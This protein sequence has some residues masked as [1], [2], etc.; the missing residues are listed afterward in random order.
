MKMT[1]LP[2]FEGE[3][4]VLWI[5]AGIHYHV[6][7]APLLLLRLTLPYRKHLCIYKVLK[8]Y[9][10]FSCPRYPIEFWY[11]GVMWFLWKA[12]QF[13]IGKEQDHFLCVV[14]KW[15]W[16]GYIHRVPLLCSCCYLWQVY[17]WLPQ[18][19]CTVA[20]QLLKDIP[21]HL[22]HLG[23]YGCVHV[24]EWYGKCKGKILYSRTTEPIVLWFIWIYMNAYVQCL[25]FHFVWYPWLVLHK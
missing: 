21:L 14:S 17:E 19:C 15:S 8:F 3:R 20:L 1:Y 11:A 16:Q 24:R 7:M 6:K 23:C 12:Q 18:R 5:R 25:P 2:D 9:C 13:S 10:F 22:L 4:F